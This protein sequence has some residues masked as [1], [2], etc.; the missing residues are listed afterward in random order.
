M[1][2]HLIYCDRDAQGLT[3]ACERC[4]VLL[5]SPAIGNAIVGWRMCLIIP[6]LAHHKATDERFSKRAW[7]QA[8]DA[9]IFARVY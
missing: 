7:L 8:E 6:D 9:D 3:I 1:S 4:E 5:D 2:Q